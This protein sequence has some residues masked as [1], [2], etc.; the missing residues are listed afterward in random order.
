MTKN[1]NLQSILDGLHTELETKQDLMI[2]PR[3]LWMSDEGKLITPANPGIDLNHHTTD[4]ALGQ[5]ASKIDAGLPI[6]YLR[7]CPPELQAENVNHWLGEMQKDNR[8]RAPWMF[9]TQGKMVR[10]ILSERYSPFDD[11]EILDVLNQMLGKGNVDTAWW[12]R[13]DGGFHLRMTFEDLTTTVGKLHDG[14][15]D[16]HKVGIHVENSEVGKKSLK[17]TPVVYRLICSNGMMG[18]ATDGDIF[19]QRHLYLK[20]H[21][22]YGRVTEAVGQALRV[23]DGAIE[24]LREAKETHIKDPL[25]VIKQLSEKNKYSK[26][27]TEKVQGRF[28]QESGD[29]AF[30]VVQAFTRASQDGSPDFQTGIETD[31]T[32]MLEELIAN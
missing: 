23:G 31:S 26:E 17:I 22:M 20:P 1:K 32:K 10:G 3:E 25:D 30:Y 2:D 13:D 15:P 8:E 11:H 21:E 16:V 28:M 14:T 4:W 7:K 29:N 5:L 19:K 12:H 9:R 18:W 6:R 27:F 24:K